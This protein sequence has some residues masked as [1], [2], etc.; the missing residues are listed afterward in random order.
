MGNLQSE[1]ERNVSQVLRSAA[2]QYGS[3]VMQYANALSSYG[4]GEIDAAQV[5]ET[6]L[7]LV[8]SESRQ[9]IELGIGLAS[10]YA[11]WAVSLVGI[12]DLK[13]ETRTVSPPGERGEGNEP[14]A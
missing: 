4:K 6:T 9:A 10:A 11:K 5:A 1:I 8:A 12:N 3:A 13:V 7:K 14:K 2:S